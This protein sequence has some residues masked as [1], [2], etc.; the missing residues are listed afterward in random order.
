[1]SARHIA[2]EEFQRNIG[3]ALHRVRNDKETLVVT[4]HGRPSIAVLSMQEYES[5]R[6]AERELKALRRASQ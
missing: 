4:N 1:M 3:E 6:A 5:L 2:S